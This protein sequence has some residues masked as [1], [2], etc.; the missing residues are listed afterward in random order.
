ME[1]E[2]IPAVRDSKYFDDL[3]GRIY[4]LISEVAAR[5]FR[6][7][8]SAFEQS[9]SE[10][11]K[12]LITNI[13]S[14]LGDTTRL[15]LP[16]DLSH[17]FERLDFLSGE[18]SV[19]L[20]NRGDGIKARY[21]PLIL[22]FMAQKKAE[23]QGRGGQPTSF[24]WAYEEPENNLEFSNSIALSDELV[25]R[26]EEN[27][28]QILIT[29]HS[30]VFYDL[31]KKNEKIFLHHVFR[32]SNLEGTKTVNEGKGIDESLGTLAILEPRISEVI[33]SV[34]EQEAEIASLKSQVESYAKPVLITEGKFDV[35]ILKTAWVKLYPEKVIP[36]EVVS[37]SSI[38]T[39]D[40]AGVRT[41]RQYLESVLPSDLSIKIGI[42]D[43]DEEGV[44]YFNKLSTHLFRKQP[45]K[46]VKRHQNGKAYAILLPQVHDIENEYW[47]SKGPCIEFLFS[48]DYFKA[49]YV[50]EK[51]RLNGGNLSKEQ[52]EELKNNDLFSYQLEY[53]VKPKKQGSTKRVFAENKV[54]TFSKEAFENFKPLFDDITEIL[55]TEDE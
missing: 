5:T 50:N 52:G 49:N 21:I 14:A 33:D 51:Y 15:A 40:T 1:F 54:S 42:F 19:S 23:L 47:D 27:I 18:Q 3:R 2:Y 55:N 29:T 25:T 36:F 38:E 35:P 7:S 12:D 6:T 39:D 31:S 32:N 43:R 53:E 34:R 46:D 9:I 45:N 20:E 44:N 11:L 41:L 30:P 24:V 13:D 48:K 16:R 17:I 26:S 37:C 22:T 28:A 8:S 10:H 4:S